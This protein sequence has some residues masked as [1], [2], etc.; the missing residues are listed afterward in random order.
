[1]A[2]DDAV[3]DTFKIKLNLGG[4]WLE[5]LGSGLVFTPAAPAWT[6]TVA[7]LGLTISGLG[8]GVGAVARWT[9]I[10]VGAAASLYTVAARTAAATAVRL[11]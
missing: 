5:G 4:V 9:G 2:E 3:L 8:P 10:A 1:M 6:P 7:G 11:A